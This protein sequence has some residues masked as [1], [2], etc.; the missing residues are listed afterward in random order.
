MLIVLTAGTSLLSEERGTLSVTHDDRSVSSDFQ[1]ARQREIVEVAVDRALVFL[2]SQ[3]RADGSFASPSGGQP[4]VTSL[5]VMAFLSCGHVPGQGTYGKQVH[6]AIDFVLSSQRPNGLICYSQP[7]SYFQLHMASHTGLYNHAIAGLMLCE[8]YGMVDSRMNQRIRSAIPKAIRLSREYQYKFKRHKGDEGGWR[9]MRQER[10]SV[11]DSDLSVAGWQIMFFRS[12][13][14][15]GFK[16]PRQYIDD[17]VRYVKRC[18]DDQRQLFRYR[19]YGADRLPTR[20]MSGAGILSLALAGE[21]HTE[22]VQSAGKWILSQ[23]FDDYNAAPH[24]KDQYHYSVFYCS[25]AMF[26]LGGDYWATFYPPLVKTLLKHQR[27]DGS[28]DRE[29]NGVGHFDNSYTTALVVL[30]LTPPYQI[31]PIYQR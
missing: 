31:L 4:A 1:N 17:G 18:Y 25:Q 21:H 23:S 29:S 9:Y 2:A 5:C 3:Q 28:W 14:N 13:K 12:A 24:R 8:V 10:R 19:L 30:S 26:Q 6:R 15:A 22:M 16:V 7:K 11:S 20:A 27:P